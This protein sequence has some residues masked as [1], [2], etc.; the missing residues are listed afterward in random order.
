MRRYCN[1]L[2]NQS[3]F[4][5]SNM[6]HTDIYIYIYTYILMHGANMKITV[7]CSFYL[8]LGQYCI[9]LTKYDSCV[10]SMRMGIFK[11]QNMLE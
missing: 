3:T 7:E 11:S 9:F 6:T 2:W 10:Y 4:Y 8:Y 5:R 1:L